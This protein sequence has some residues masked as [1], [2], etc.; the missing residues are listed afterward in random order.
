[1]EL[2]EILF[3]FLW[4]SKVDKVKR[5]TVTQEYQN[6]GLKMINLDNYIKGLKSTWIRRL[7]I[8]NNAE[9]Q[10]LVSYLFNSEK[11]IKTRSGYI[12]E[13]QGTLK[14][15]FW[16]DVLSAYKEIQNKSLIHNSED[17]LSKPLWYNKNIQ[18]NNKSVFYQS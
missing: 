13:I 16:L 17:F 1:M 8:D 11:L 12:D 10:K 7:L 3:S 9:W 6:G 4:K 2:N 15:K 14:N 18:I 5:K